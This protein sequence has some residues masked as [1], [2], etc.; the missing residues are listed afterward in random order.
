M[1][2]VVQT[3]KVQSRHSCKMILL[4]MVTKVM[5]L[6]PAIFTSI[7]ERVCGGGALDD[8]EGVRSVRCGTALST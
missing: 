4:V 6:H 8:E 5:L 1:V 7:M 2:V 3:I